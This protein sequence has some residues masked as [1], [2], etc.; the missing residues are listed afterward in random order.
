M[1]SYN[2]LLKEIVNNYLGDL[3]IRPVKPEPEEIEQEL[4]SIIQEE[5]TKLKSTLPKNSRLN[6]PMTLSATV[7]TELII[8]LYSV[9]RIM[10]ANSNDEENCD[11]AIYCDEGENEG[12]YVFDDSVF[13][14]LIKRFNY[15]VDIK[16]INEIKERLFYQAPLCKRCENRDLIAVNNGIFNYK[17]KIFMP[18]SPDY[19][20]TTKSR[21]NYYPNAPLT[22][23]HNDSDNTDWDV[24]SWIRS[25]CDTDDVYH[26]LWEIIGA[27]IR[28]N[29][30]WN[31]LVFFYSTFGNNGKGTFCRLLRNICGE[32]SC[33]ALPLEKFSQEF[34]LEPLTRASAVITDENSTKS[35]L[36]DTGSLKAAVTGD[37]LF[38]N[39]KYK[40]PISLKFNGLVVQC[41]NA[42]PRFSDKT[43]SLL[44]R[45]IF[46]PFNK[47]FTGKERKYIKDDYLQRK[48]VLE[49]VLCQVLHSNYYN[50][51]V[52]NECI[53]L[54]EE[55]KQYNDPVKDFLDEFLDKYVWDL[56][57]YQFLYDHFV[58]WFKKTN[59]SGT[60]IGKNT[61]IGQVKS[62]LRNNE[63]WEAK[64]TA[65]PTGNKMNKYEDI[66]YDFY[67]CGWTDTGYRGRKSSYKGIVRR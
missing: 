65:V 24:N 46:I 50:L 37:E 62:L 49:Y 45:F 19:V 2:N 51:D 35:F 42:L 54:L 58:S 18:F 25:L 61:F 48:D 13:Y 36:K 60:E 56:L 38:I 4:L 52:P 15:D 33:V 30:S 40:K 43:E 5:F 17:N 28:P 55:F 64:S 44:R 7:I 23:I 10:W 21:V 1:S 66:V 22:V 11:L 27:V 14:K 29:V 47:C 26:L 59:V 34:M 12:L 8:N 53:E 3:K 6:M 57:P 20:F 41:I 31:K 67:L 16:S 32:N 39:R 9:K 63:Q